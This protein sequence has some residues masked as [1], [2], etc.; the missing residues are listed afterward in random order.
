MRRRGITDI[1]TT[2]IPIL[3]VLILI[4]AGVNLVDPIKDFIWKYNNWDQVLEQRGD[5]LLTQH[6]FVADRVYV[7]EPKEYTE[8]IALDNADYYHNVRVGADITLEQTKIQFKNGDVFRQISTPYSEE[9]KTTNIDT[10]KLIYQYQYPIG[11]SYYYDKAAGSWVDQGK[12]HGG[13]SMPK[14]TLA[15]LNYGD[16]LYVLTNSIYAYEK[17]DE[18]VES[19][20]ETSGDTF[21]SND[22]SIWQIIMSYHNIEGRHNEHWILE[23]AQPLVDFDAP[24]LLDDRR[25]LSDGLYE[26]VQEGF[27]PY[28]KDYFFRKTVDKDLTDMS[29]SSNRADSEVAYAQLLVSTLSQAENG[30]FEAVLQNTELYDKYGMKYGYVDVLENAEKG[31]QLIKAAE[32]YKETGFDDAISKLA[33]FFKTFIEENKREAGEKIE[34]PAY[35]RNGSDCSEVAADEAATAALKDF[36]KQYAAKYG[37][38]EAADL[39]GML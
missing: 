36:L 15:Y 37:D 16:Q 4:Y 34:V 2:V 17:K 18:G 24:M 19:F 14:D 9:V 31:I 33:G 3:M 5:R 7:E 13:S 21:L 30:S 20:I 10:L 32:T 12:F 39:A 25:I 22:G 6:L 28:S 11:Y 38:L 26:H 29:L 23:S 27:T 1:L 8:H 35:W